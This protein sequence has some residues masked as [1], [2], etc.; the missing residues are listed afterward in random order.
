[1]H[2][3]LTSPPTGSPI[4]GS[5]P[6]HQSRIG[7]T[8]GRVQ[9][10]LEQ[11]SDGVP[12]FPRTPSCHPSLSKHY[13]R[14]R[15][16]PSSGISYDSSD[17]D[18]VGPITP[19][20]ILRNLALYVKNAKER[21]EPYKRTNP[22]I[23]E[24]FCGEECSGCNG[25]TIPLDNPRPFQDSARLARRMKSLSPEAR[26]QAVVAIGANVEWRRARAVAA[27]L[28]ID[29]IV[30]H[31][32]FMCLTLESEAKTYVNAISEPLEISIEVLANC[33]ASEID[34]HESCSVAAYELELESFAIADKELDHAKSLTLQLMDSD[35]SATS[36]DED[37]SGGSFGSMSGT[38]R[39]STESDD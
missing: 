26:A 13:K 6:D 12:I 30:Q 27:A 33:T 29:A 25:S 8:A 24:R 21:P 3:C 20:P 39:T 2:A 14:P 19:P 32:K 1:M 10:K 34:D 4:R 7:R 37:N 5:N 15:S 35:A 31:K 36:S 11:G 28:Q 23:I 38:S 22:N 17:D 18:I 9:R 16:P